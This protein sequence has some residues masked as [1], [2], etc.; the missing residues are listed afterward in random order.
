MY[1]DHSLSYQR[2]SWCLYSTGFLRLRNLYFNRNIL[3]SSLFLLFS[4]V[5]ARVDVSTPVVALGLP[6]Q[7]NT[8][9]VGVLG[10]Y[11]RN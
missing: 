6:I 10:S 11:T 3:L 5:D 4:Q 7:R 1:L 8:D 9:C 2:R